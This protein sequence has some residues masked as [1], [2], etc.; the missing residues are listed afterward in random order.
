MILASNQDCGAWGD[1]FGDLIIASAI[2][3]RLLHHA[4]TLDIRGNSCGLKE[5]LNAGLVRSFDDEAQPQTA[6]KI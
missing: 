5:N 2:F 4:M 6:G 1:I 3:D